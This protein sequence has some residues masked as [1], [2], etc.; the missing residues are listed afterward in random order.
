MDISDGY[1][2]DNQHV[3]NNTVNTIMERFEHSFISRGIT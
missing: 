3:N 1:R 2:G